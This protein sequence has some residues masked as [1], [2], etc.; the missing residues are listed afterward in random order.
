MV[1]PAANGAAPIAGAQKPAIV[2]DAK[3][4]GPAPDTKGDKAAAPPP[5]GALTVKP[6]VVH[7]HKQMNQKVDEAVLQA[8]S[9][10]LLPRLGQPQPAAA[11]PRPPPRNHV[12]RVREVV[13]T[14]TALVKLDTA[15]NTTHARAFL[16]QIEKAGKDFGTNFGLSHAPGKGN[17]LNADAFKG[18]SRNPLMRD[19]MDQP[20]L[21]ERYIVNQRLVAEFDNE[22]AAPGKAQA[23]LGKV[24]GL[25]GDKNTQGVSQD[26]LKA[27][28]KAETTSRG[29]RAA[30]ETVLTTWRD[31]GNMK[32]VLNA[33]P[34]GVLS[35]LQSALASPPGSAN[36]AV[37]AD[38]SKVDAR[39]LVERIGADQTRPG[40]S[41]I[42]KN[43]IDTVRND[44]KTTAA[45]K[46]VLSCVV[47]ERYAS[48]DAPLIYGGDLMK[49]I[50]NVK[51]NGA[52]PNRTGVTVNASGDPRIAVA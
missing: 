30:I 5:G 6:K 38:L 49:I 25:Q 46:W 1:N 35:V 51:Q 52:P 4:A 7:A 15:S 22:K 14:Y 9:K 37:P 18:L 45:E 44:P 29:D 31:A 47:E 23:L 24:N 11:M 34:Q 40:E 41:P 10:L 19:K 3:G 26:E 16:G 36:T 43:Q 12:E 48:P 50:D 32:N 13:S 2:A 28:A 8:R 21:R 20:N 17:A 27:V 33:S 39:Q 42:T